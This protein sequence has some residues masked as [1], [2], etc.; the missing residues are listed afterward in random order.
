MLDDHRGKNVKFT[1]EQT[2]KAQKGRRG[3]AVLFL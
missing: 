1:A 2:T 3:I